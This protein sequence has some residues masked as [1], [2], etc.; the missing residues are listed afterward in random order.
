[1][2]IGFFLL[3]GITDPALPLAELPQT[4]LL[5]AI[6]KSDCYVSVLLAFVPGAFRFASV[7][8]P[9]SSFAMPFVVDELAF[10]LATI[11]PGL[12]AKAL[13]LIVE[14]V[15]CVGLSIT[16]SKLAFAKASILLELSFVFAAI[17]PGKGT[18]PI[19]HVFLILALVDSH[20]LSADEAA[21]AI[22][23]VV[24]VPALVY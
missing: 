22:G 17:I 24:E 2:L 19:H 20:V 4:S 15:P 1:M 21:L 13:L 5:C 23:Q 3:T 10:V 8:K 18:V 6:F 14:P 12:H 11:L 7:G 16:S 9:L